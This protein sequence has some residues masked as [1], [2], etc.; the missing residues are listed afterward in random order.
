MEE[1]KS[2][3]EDFLWFEYDDSEKPFDFI[4]TDTETALI[5]V[6]DESLR[7]QITEDL[8]NRDFYNTEVKT[9]KEALRKML[10][11]TYTLLVVDENFD[12]TTPDSNDLIRYLANTPMSTRRRMFVAL[13]S[14]RIRSL[15]RMAALDQSV[16]MIIN[17]S[18]MKD[19]ITLVT[20]GM[21]ENE[22]FYHTFA[23]VMKIS[24]KE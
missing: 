16:N 2:L 20:N 12:T 4:G 11:H 6:T 18:S 7:N 13:I 1:T 9:A 10:F 23:D 3:A 22:G 5:C 14:R 21:A 19:F 8:K 17:I 15:D 24:G